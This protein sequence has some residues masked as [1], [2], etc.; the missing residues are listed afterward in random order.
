MGLRSRS[1]PLL[2]YSLKK[3][4]TKSPFGRQ[5]RTGRRPAFRRPFGPHSSSSWTMGSP[6]R[7]RGSVTFSSA[8][9]PSIIGHVLS[10][11]RS[12]PWTARDHELSLPSGRVRL[13]ARYHR[14][15][16]PTGTPEVHVAITG[17]DGVIRSR[18]G[19][20]WSRCRLARR[21]FRLERTRRNVLQV[22]AKSHGSAAFRSRFRPRHR[23]R[24]LLAKPHD[25][26]RMDPALTFR[27]FEPSRHERG[28]RKCSHFRNDQRAAS[29][30]RTPLR[31]RTLVGLG[32]THD[33]LAQVETSYLFP[34]RRSRSAIRK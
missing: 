32:A 27:C 29:D 5:D 20:A 9:A 23:R 13:S 33:K 16:D 8:A 26:G 15:I 30:E 21:G 31:E 10:F 12:K 22:S 25:V 34:V 19:D 14:S 18:R 6:R 17:K 24:A 11:S 4:R 7:Q 3:A 2:Y 28:R 1:G